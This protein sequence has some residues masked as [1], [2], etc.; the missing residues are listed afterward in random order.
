ME[1]S[2]VVV[3]HQRLKKKS[4]RGKE[5]E[6]SHLALKVLSWVKGQSSLGGAKGY[7]KRPLNRLHWENEGFKIAASIRECR[8]GR[9]GKE[10]R[11]ILESGSL[12]RKKLFRFFLKT[13]K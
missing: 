8:K 4:C 9:I 12:L 5:R 1:L 3:Q 10:E 7:K 2:D 6:D 13:N 11:V